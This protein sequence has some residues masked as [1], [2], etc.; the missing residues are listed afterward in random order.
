MKLVARVRV[1]I[2]DDE[3]AKWGITTKDV[4]IELRALF[5]PRPYMPKG[6]TLGAIEFIAFEEEN[7]AAK[8]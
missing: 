6:Y 2:P 1:I 8:M 5:R 4:E 7:D 3:V